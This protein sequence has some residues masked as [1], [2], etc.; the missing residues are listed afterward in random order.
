MNDPGKY[1]RL[2][3]M[4]LLVTTAILITLI[5]LFLCIKFVF[6]IINELPL[7]TYIYTLFVL[8]VPA[9]LFIT[10]FIIFYRR[11]INYPSRPVR[12]ISYGLFII[13]LVLWILFYIMDLIAF[14]KT[15]Q[16]Q[17]AEYNCWDVIFLTSSVACIFIVGI[18]QALNGEKEEDWMERRR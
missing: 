17:V 16:I 5:L 2:A 12:F 14:F 3:G 9:A 7:V 1:I 4:L 15:A 11:T 18:I 13:F 10:T 8:S 6:G